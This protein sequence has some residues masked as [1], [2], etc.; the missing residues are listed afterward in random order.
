[1]LV[2]KNGV[3]KTIK[4]LLI[5]TPTPNKKQEVIPI[6]GRHFN[7]K[8]VN[9]NLVEKVDQQLYVFITEILLKKN[10]NLMVELLLIENG[11]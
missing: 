5:E 4:T 11:N 1:M 7:I 10:F 8:V 2:D 6:S 3:I 9:V